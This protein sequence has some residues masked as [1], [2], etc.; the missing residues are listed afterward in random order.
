[1]SNRVTTFS[2]VFPK[3]HSR[4]GEPTYFEEKIWSG[5]LRMDSFFYAQFLPWHDDED[6]T[7]FNALYMKLK[8]FE[9][10]YHTIRQG[11]RWK[12]G[13]DMDMRVWTGKPYR[14]KQRMIVPDCVVPIVKVWNIAKVGEM[15]IFDHHIIN[16]SILPTIAQND[17]LSVQNFYHWFE[18]CGKYKR[19]E[20]QIISWCKD[21]AYAV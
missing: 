2:T 13:D 16:T 21:I 1:M 8:T 5:L 3:M 11:N 12:V 19:W 14:S 18:R 20:G 10:K 17:G 6:P 9:P 7:K 4:A 15:F